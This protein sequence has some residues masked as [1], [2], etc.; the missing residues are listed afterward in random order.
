MLTIKQRKEA[1]IMSKKPGI[2]SEFKEFISKGSVLDMAVGIIIG[3]AFTSIVNSLVNDML[4]PFIGWLIGGKN[5]E[6]FKIVL[7]PAAGDIPESAIYYGK[8]IQS[9]VNFLLIALVI[10]LM[11]RSINKLRNRKKKEEEEAE[12]AVEEAPAEPS[13]E[14]LLLREIRD[15]LKSEKADE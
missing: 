3:G 7:T 5:F 11:V 10:F 8:F 1:D 14:V 2:I 13:E 4:M 12:A 9:I 15:S 6:D